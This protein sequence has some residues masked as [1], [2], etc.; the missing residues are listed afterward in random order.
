V[1]SRLGDGTFVVFAECPD[2]PWLFAHAPNEF[3]G[4]AL[5]S[6]EPRT[7]ASAGPMNTQQ[8]GDRGSAAP[9]LPR[10]PTTG[11]DDPKRPLPKTRSTATDAIRLA[12]A[13]IM[14]RNSLRK[15]RLA[16]KG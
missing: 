6:M 7:P 11:G 4:N 10:M 15:Q 8:P 2:L 16:Q 13:K 12:K 3:G 1:N 5:S 9:M 14:R